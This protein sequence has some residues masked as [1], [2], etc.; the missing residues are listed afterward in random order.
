MDDSFKKQNQNKYK[1]FSTPLNKHF[2]S[3]IEYESYALKEKK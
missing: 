2:L 1:L 3:G